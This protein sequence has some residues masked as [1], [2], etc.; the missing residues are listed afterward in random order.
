MQGRTQA[1]QGG[2]ECACQ[3]AAL[4][5]A[6]GS[7]DKFRL[8]EVDGGRSAEGEQL[9]TQ[10]RCGGRH[11]MS[12]QSR[13]ALLFIVNL[14]FETCLNILWHPATCAT[15]PCCTV[16]LTCCISKPGLRDGNISQSSR[17]I[18]CST[19]ASHFSM[20]GHHRREAILVLQS[21]RLALLRRDRAE[22]LEEE[23]RLW[24]HA[25]ARQLSVQP[26]TCG[27]EVTQRGLEPPRRPHN[28]GAQYPRLVVHIFRSIFT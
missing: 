13:L 28:L 6:A 12:R 3:L 2:W 20:G 23:A 21:T 7:P 24:R 9:Q 27:C 22:S 5:K 1:R 14:H 17:A 8:R 10:Q 11:H 15:N 25:E 26:V 4:D 19:H 16:S 18:S